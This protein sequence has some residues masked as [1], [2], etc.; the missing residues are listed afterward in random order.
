[1][2]GATFSTRQQQKIDEIVLGILFIQACSNTNDSHG[3]LLMLGQKCYA[4]HASDTHVRAVGVSQ[5]FGR[6]LTA[7]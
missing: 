5:S 4:Y 7:L 1:M 6:L 2:M 3:Y